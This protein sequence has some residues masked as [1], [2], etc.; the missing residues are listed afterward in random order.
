M[1]NFLLLIWDTVS[2]S[3]LNYLVFPKQHMLNYLHLSTANLWATGSLL[4]PLLSLPVRNREGSW[5]T[6]ESFWTRHQCLKWCCDI[7]VLQSSDEGD[8]SDSTKFEDAECI[9]FPMDHPCWKQVAGCKLLPRSSA[10]SC[11]VF[12]F[13]FFFSVCQCYSSDFFCITFDFP[14][15]KPKHKTEKVKFFLNEQTSL[16][17]TVQ[18]WWSMWNWRQPCYPEKQLPMLC[19][20]CFQNHNYLISG[21]FW[22]LF[23]TCSLQCVHRLI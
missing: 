1:N 12:G 20:D 14:Y 17:E 22:F 8:S 10:E 19:S 15:Y 5:L 2:I 21:S 11:E 13:V 3:S 23:S 7:A 6:E 18:L 4:K 9:S 16:V